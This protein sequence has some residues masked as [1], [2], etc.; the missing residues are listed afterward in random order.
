[1]PTATPLP[2]PTPTPA[3]ARLGTPGLVSPTVDQ[4]FTNPPKNVTFSWRTVSNAAR[5]NLEVEENISGWV[6]R[7]NTQVTG[8]TYSKSIGFGATQWRYRVTAIGTGSYTNSTPS[9]WRYFSFRIG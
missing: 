1:M 3:P 2:T 6:N 5:Y 7:V 9:D 8:T 4:I